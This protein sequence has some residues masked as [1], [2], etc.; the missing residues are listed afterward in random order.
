MKSGLANASILEELAPGPVVISRV[1]RSARWGREH[2]VAVLPHR[3]GEQPLLVLLRSVLFEMGDQRCGQHDG[4]GAGSAL[5]RH[6]CEAFAFD[7]LKRSPDSEDALAEVDV[8][9]LQTKCFALAQ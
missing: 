2:E 3:A 4:A 7:A 8:R 9:P 6:Q 1:N 5:R